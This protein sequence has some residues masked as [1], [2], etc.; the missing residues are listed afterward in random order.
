MEKFLNLSFQGTGGTLAG[1]GCYLKSKDPSIRVIL[2]DPQGSGLYNKVKLFE[3]AKE[4]LMARG[5]R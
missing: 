4:Y 1:T 3:K 2:A 5:D